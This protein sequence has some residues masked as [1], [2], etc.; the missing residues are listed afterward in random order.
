MPFNFKNWFGGI[1]VKPDNH[2]EKAQD[3][4][5]EVQLDDENDAKTSISRNS[6]QVAGEEWLNLNWDE[7]FF[8]KPFQVEDRDYKEL[9]EWTKTHPV[10]EMYMNLAEIDDWFPVE[11][12]GI[13]LYFP[14]HFNVGALRF[15]LMP[16]FPQTKNKSCF[17]G[18]MGI[19]VAY[20]C[21][22]NHSIAVVKTSVF[23][24]SESLE[25]EAYEILNFL[26]AN[27]KM[28]VGGHG[29]CSEHFIKFTAGTVKE[30]SP[31]FHA[32]KTLKQSYVMI[33]KMDLDLAVLHKQELPLFRNLYALR[34]IF[35]SMAEG[36]QCMHDAKPKGIAHGDFKPANI[37]CSP[38]TD[39]W[40]ELVQQH[41]ASL[42]QHNVMYVKMADFD[43]AFTRVWD[44]DRQPLQLYTIFVTSP[45]RLVD[46]LASKEDD[47]WALGVSFLDLSTYGKQADRIS[48][49]LLWLLEDDEYL[50]RPSSL[51]SIQ[52]AVKISVADAVLEWNRSWKG[53]RFFAKPG[54]IKE[55]ADLISKCLEVDVKKRITIDEILKHPFMTNL[56]S[57]YTNNK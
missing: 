25:Q 8:H 28:P 37:L 34:F 47:V 30:L 48:R 22:Q 38:Y 24:G 46:R 32:G 50:A 20:E 7:A 15:V 3:I 55:L 40:I 5:P 35:R 31:P 52:R 54:A 13:T 23:R 42:L 53:L 19:V 11:H 57:K 12:E 14:L 51:E 18:S 21:V 16:I 27:G 6:K 45:Q 17:M 49:Q 43:A 26:I 56:E 4:V 39:Q 33:E 29:A 36:L 41:K 9:R 44:L 10:A 1:A 2:K